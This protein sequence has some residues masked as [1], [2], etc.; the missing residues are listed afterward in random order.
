MADESSLRNSGGADETTPMAQGASSEC[1]AESGVPEIRI[2]KAQVPAEVNG[3]STTVELFTMSMGEEAIY[4]APLKTW[5]QLDLFKWRV[6]GKLPGTPAGLEIAADHVKLAGETIWTSDLD[7]CAKLE[8]AFNQWLALERGTIE[9]AKQK[10]QTTAP[11]EPVATADEELPHY[12]IEMD[13][14]AQPHIVCMEG[15]DVAAN[16]AITAIGINSL[17]TQGLIRRPQDWKIGA[18]REW[19]EL[20]GHVFKIK[21]GDAGLLE[22]ERA[23]NE[24]Y[25]PAGAGDSGRDVMV[26]ANPGSS[27]GFDIQF[28][29]I[30][31]VVENK[32]RHLDIEAMELLSD[33]QRCRVLRKGIIVKLAPPDL[34]FK[35]QTADGG[36]R[37]LEPGPQNAIM[38][39]GPDGQRKAIDLSQPVS[40]L[41]LGA[42][43]LTEIFN[44]PSVNRRA[45][46]KLQ[47]EGGF[48][49]WLEAA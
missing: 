19:I 32:R 3:Q 45:R 26:F 20:D 33:P 13:K 40:H 49:G 27:S 29:V 30:E 46:R 11:A 25:V 38:V 9:L 31:G 24:R 1:P 15:R 39:T 28:P 44:H 48:D 22:L 6:Q 37:N 47:A 12:K 35:M 5:S 34:I 21:D 2:G 8:R 4:L 18:L 10:A 41:G 43:E 7:G 16:V 42:P 36:E 17:I 23:L 14:T